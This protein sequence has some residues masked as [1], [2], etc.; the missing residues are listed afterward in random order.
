MVGVCEVGLIVV[1]FEVWDIGIGMDEV[2]MVCIFEWF[3]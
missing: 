1:W 2:V 3:M